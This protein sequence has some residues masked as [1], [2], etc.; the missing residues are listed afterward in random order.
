MDHLKDGSPKWNCLCPMISHNTLLYIQSV[1]MHSCM[2][3]HGLC[4]YLIRLV[5]A[6]LF[7]TDNLWPIDT[8]IVSG[9][10][11]ISELPRAVRNPWPLLEEKVLKVIGQIG[12]QFKIS[13]TQNST[14]YGYGSHYWN[15]KEGMDVGCWI[16]RYKMTEPHNSWVE[17]WLRTL[18]GK[19]CESR[20]ISF[21]HQILPRS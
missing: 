5:L 10:V 17:S 20:R 7:P 8:S 18:S 12:A 11:N 9:G 3:F 6:A 15:L 16:Q 1:L 2:P 19:Y 21:L 14:S 13:N 4:S